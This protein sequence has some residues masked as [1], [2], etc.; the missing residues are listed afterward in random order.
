MNY[1][2]EEVKSLIGHLSSYGDTYEYLIEFFQHYLPD[3]QKWGLTVPPSTMSSAIII[4]EL[5]DLF[6]DVYFALTMPEKDLPLYIDANVGL[7]YP[8]AVWRLRSCERESPR[9]RGFASRIKKGVVC[10]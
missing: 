7:E 3:T 1:T 2:G 4:E 5:K 6:P 10:K 9:R 8:I